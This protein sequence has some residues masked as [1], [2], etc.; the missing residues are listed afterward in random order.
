MPRANTQQQIAITKDF[1][2]FLRS[3]NLKPDSK[4]ELRNIYYDEFKKGLIP[5]GPT[6]AFSSILYHLKRMKRLT[7]GSEPDSILYYERRGKKMVIAVDQT[8]VQRR[9]NRQSGQKRKDVNDKEVPRNQSFVEDLKKV[10]L[11]NKDILTEDKKNVRIYSDLDISHGVI[12]FG[13]FPVNGSSEV[14]EITIK[15]TGATPVKLKRF[16]ALDKVSEFIL[17]DKHRVTEMNSETFKV[18]K[19]NSLKQYRISALF[20]PLSLGN[21]KLPIVFEFEEEGPETKVF[22]VARFLVGQATDEAVRSI[23]PTAEYHHPSPLAKIYDP[24]VDVIAGVPPDTHESRLVYKVRLN[25]YRIPFELRVSLNKGN[26]NSHLEE[27]LQAELS[28]RNYRERFAA[29]LHIEEMQM[30]VDIHHYDKH[31]AT[32]TRDGPFLVLKVPGL[33]ENRPSVI[34]GDHLY[35]RIQDK[36]GVAED[37]EYQGFVHHV[38]LNDVKLKF[39]QSFH[40]KYIKGMK[41]QVRFTFGRTPLKIMHRSLQLHSD[42]VE[43]DQVLALNKE[44]GQH[45]ERVCPVQVVKKLFNAKLEK[46]PEQFQAVTN[47]VLGTSRPAP[48]LIFGPPGTG[49]TVTVVEAIKQV[50]KLFK[51]SHVLACAPS[52]SAADLILERVIEHNVVP[53][54][55]MLRLNAYGR[56]Q[57]TLPE[58]IKPF[59]CIEDKEFFFPSVEDIM[60]KRLVVCTLITSGRLV[61]AGIT[62]KHFTHVFIDEA[63]HSLEPECLVPLAGLINP[64]NPGGGQVVL[65]GDPQQ[66]GPVLRSPI[67]VKYGL[68]VSLLERIMTKTPYYGRI[69]DEDDEEDELGEY[70]PLLL[71]KLLKNYRSHPAI[72]ELPNEMFYDDELEACADELKR[73]SLC[74]WSKL[75]TKDFPIIFHGVKGRDMREENSPSFFNPEEAVTVVKCVKDLRDSR[76]VNILTKDI[77]IISP[78]RKQVSKIRQLLSHENIHD[79]KVGSVEEFQGQERRVIIISTVRSSQEYLQVDARFRLGFLKNPKRFNVAI[80]R[81]QALLIVVGNPYILCKDSHWGRLIQYCVKHKAY[82]GCDFILPDEEEEELVRRLKRVHLHSQEAYSNLTQDQDQNLAAAEEQPWHRPEDH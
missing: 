54:A 45:L 59:C 20:K 41:V 8:Y 58:S 2:K 48:Y 79:A 82:R 65:A 62:D 67:A 75:P 42:V 69:L 5:S 63:G 70:N 10:F 26:P 32:M 38:E 61:S 18:L 46:N 31:N 64:R 25:Q 68:G 73:N 66:L 7:K 60:S 14:L 6:V 11:K 78:Y 81:A 12:D 50:L 56:S 3:K 1:W 13:E 21:F 74:Q 57:S 28:S 55:Q 33:A 16:A 47:I 27:L 35:V 72:L 77:G 4:Q 24:K 43:F 22:H 23:L 51:N 40:K 53:K 30:E 34:K 19:I 29:L 49:K 80:T 17:E 76:G 71:T 15:N 37:K 39:H 9:K 44:E 52:N 36:D